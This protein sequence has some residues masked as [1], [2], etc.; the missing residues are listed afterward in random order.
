MC[1]GRC[2]GKLIGVYLIEEARGVAT[3]SDAIAVGQPRRRQPQMGEIA[4]L[5][6][7]CGGPAAC[8]QQGD[9]LGVV[10]QRAFVVAFLLQQRAE[11]PRNPQAH[12]TG[13][14]IGEYAGGRETAHR[15][16]RFREEKPLPKRIVL[17]RGDVRGQHQ[18]FGEQRR[19][20]V[21]QPKLAQTCGSR[22]VRTLRQRRPSGLQQL[23]GQRVYR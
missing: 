13:V 1:F 14:G 6:R 3:G 19:V 10:A 4:P 7:R 8:R 20:G 2:A 5:D 23:R 11:P 16:P 15:A 12:T 17:R 22:V 18:R 21:E 9:R